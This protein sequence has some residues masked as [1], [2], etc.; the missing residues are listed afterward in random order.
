MIGRPPR[1]RRPDVCGHGSVLLALV[2]NV[3]DI[4]HG[5]SAATARTT[6]APGIGLPGRQGAI[7]LGSDFYFRKSRGPAP[8]DLQFG[9]ALQHYAY[10]LASSFLG[11]LSGVCA[12]AINTKLTTEASAHVILM[13]VDICF[14]NLQRLSVLAGQSGNILCGDVGEKMVAVSPLG[15]RAMAFQA[16]MRDHRTAIN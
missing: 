7:F 4:R 12:P 8:G 1:S 15:D 2:R 14:R 5:R 6:C 11:N 9:I 3:Y 13:H 10:G 16:T